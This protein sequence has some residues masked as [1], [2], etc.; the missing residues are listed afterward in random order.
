VC[1]L[2]KGGKVNKRRTKMENKLNFCRASDEG[3]KYQT[4]L[5]AASMLR[6]NKPFKALFGQL[7][8]ATEQSKN[9]VFNAATSCCR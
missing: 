7:K 3:M 9:D 8:R 2:V 1:R 4:P 6:L 5:Q